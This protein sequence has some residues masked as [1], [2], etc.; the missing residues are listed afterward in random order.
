MDAA[1]A[2]GEAASTAPFSSLTGRWWASK[3]MKRFRRNP[4][5]LLG[6]LIIVIFVAVAIFAPQLTTLGRSCLHDLGLTADTAQEVRHPLKSV[7]WRAILA[8]PTRCYTIPRAGFAQIPQPP[9][10][11]YLLGTTSGGYDI[12]YGLVWGTRTAFLV[13]LVVVGA[14]LTGGI[15]AG[16]LSGYFGGLLDSILMRFTDIVLAFPGLVLAMVI[17]SILGQNLRSVMIALAT[18]TWPYYARLL[19]GD[20]LRIKEQDYIAGA[21]ALGARN[22][23]I[24][25][26]HVL[27]NAI[28]SLLIIASLDIGSVVITAAALSFL[29]L[30][31]PAGYADWGQM[32]SFARNWILGPP[33]QPLAYWYVSFWPGLIIV[34]F[35]LGWNLLGEAFRDML[36]PHGT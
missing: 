21:K 16:S 35:G 23:Y 18:V 28:G 10:R 11:E 14:G 4:L 7:F 8:P 33:G 20:I 22:L 34:L 5:A 29:G 13:G 24:I 30:G 19:R 36:D 1:T 6:T 27:P 9:S 15:I 2:P 26:K 17:V 25:F 31:A 32:I 12:F 3:R